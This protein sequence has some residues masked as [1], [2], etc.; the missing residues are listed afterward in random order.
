MTTL[1]TLNGVGGGNT[2]GGWALP[3]LTS[4]TFPPFP[5]GGKV[6]VAVMGGPGSG[7]SGSNATGSNSSPWGVKV[8][9]VSASDV[10]DITIGAGGAPKTGGVGNTGNSSIVKLNGVT[11]MTA[12]PGE[13]GQVATSATA[14]PAAAV[15][16]V[17]GADRVISGL[18]SQPNV[19]GLVSQK[20]GAAVDIFA[21]GLGRGAAGTTASAGGSVGVAS[22]S[23]A[24]P[25]APLPLY[26]AELGV[27]FFGANT[28]GLAG[29]GGL[30][31][32]SGGMFAGGGPGGPAGSGGV[33]AGGGGST[34]ASPSGQG[35]N[36][37]AYVVFV[38]EA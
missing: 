14:N 13:P 17:V 10:L 1:N 2:L 24:A 26:S 34:A 27:T 28:A 16:T 11:I 37:Y 8:I 18:Q 23:D 22:V 36:G 12:Q 35:G 5:V 3:V 4:K 19:N 6:Q 29:V 25:T 30:S 20:G 32:T 21:T 15:A 33:G 7:G 9:T 31:N 38:P